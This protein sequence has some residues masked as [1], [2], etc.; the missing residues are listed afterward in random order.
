[1]ITSN[2]GGEL[3]ARGAWKAVLKFGGTAVAVFG[4]LG[5]WRPDDDILEHTPQGMETII[6]LGEP[7]ARSS[8]TSA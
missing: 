7:A 3:F 6:R 5:A 8:R 4:E 2:R 1:M